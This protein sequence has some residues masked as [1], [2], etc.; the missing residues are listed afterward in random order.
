MCDSQKLLWVPPLPPNITHLFLSMNHIREINST[1]LSGLEQ[2]QELDL[3]RQ[4]VPLVIR[5]NAFSGQ[6]RLRKLTLGF[7]LG[8]HL[9]PKAFTGL[10]ALRD[11]D[12]DYCSLQDSI[13]EESYLEPLSS[14][15]TLN[16]FGNRIKR[17]R[18]SMFFT[19]MTNLSE[20]NLKLNRIHKICEPD[21]AGFQGKDFK[22]LNLNSA[23]LRTMSSEGFDWQ[24]CGNPFQGM[25]FQTLDLSSNGLS[26]GGLKR[27]FKAIDG[28]RISDLKLSGHV[29]SGFSFK[30]LPDPDQSTFEG[31]RNSSVINLDLSKNR[32]SALQRGVFSPLREVTY[33]DVSQNH[34]HQIHHNAFEGLQ[35][36]LK[37]LNLS[38]NLLGE[39]HSH[40]FASLTNLLILDLSYNHIGV[41][42]F[43]SFSGLPS[44]R[45]LYLTGNSLRDLGFPAPLPRLDFLLLDDNRLTS[46]S[47]RALTSF[48]SNVMHLNVQDNRLT[49][50][51]AVHTLLTE[52]KRLQH[53]LFGGNTIRLCTRGRQ[54]SEAAAVSGLQILDL[55][56]SS[57]QSVWSQG[58]CLD[59]FRNL[60]NLKGLNLSSNR[61][62]NLPQAVFKDLTSVV[63]MDL[64]SNSL[65][66]LEPD[67]LPTSL[68]TLNLANNF[69]AWPDPA[70]FSSLNSLNLNGNRFRCDPDLRGFLTWMKTTNVTLLTPAEKLRCG[71]PHNLD[72]VT[73]L[74]YSARV[75]QR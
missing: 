57:L 9:E 15:E 67:I 69:I 75:G 27:F 17:V 22:V 2:L 13:L 26:L 37:V 54:V 11:L 31:L 14:L 25:A 72:N 24:T 12:M 50:L 63:E 41:L 64:S 35:G 4:N 10:S 70:A 30:N 7:N 47:V 6:S 74:D 42:G 29:G 62:H 51:G 38:H 68:K 73:L 49:D 33:I 20:L 59:V 52:L 45:A 23:L 18:P 19:N 28:T 53:L 43:R 61:L 3:G 56:G 21:L 32:I 46:S 60:K 40:T 55:H 48:A 71:F 36:H 16:L 65:T 8:L 44:L 5:D 1:S 39:V 66:Y 58:R 34:I